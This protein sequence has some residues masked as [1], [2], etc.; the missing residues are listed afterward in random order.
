MHDKHVKGCDNL[1][2]LHLSIIVKGVIKNKKRTKKEQCD[3][4]MKKRRF[5]IFTSSSA[6]NLTLEK[7]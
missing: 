4:W 5:Q 3:K 1:F 6:H 2:K 7:L